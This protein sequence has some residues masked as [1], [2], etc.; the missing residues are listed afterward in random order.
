MRGKYV[1]EVR[2]CTLILLALL[3]CCF[4]CHRKTTSY[5]AI[6]AVNQPD[7]DSIFFVNEIV[8]KDAYTGEYRV[9][10]L[11]RV[12]KENTLP[13]RIFEANTPVYRTNEL[14]VGMIQ[15]PPKCFDCSAAQDMFLLLK[16]NKER[17]LMPLGYYKPDT[18]CAANGVTLP[19]DVARLCVTDSDF[20]T[21]LL[22][23]THYPMRL[24]S[25]WTSPPRWGRYFLNLKDMRQVNDSASLSTFIHL[26]NDT[27]IVPI[28]LPQATDFV[29]WNDLVDK[30]D[31]LPPAQK[32][33]NG[34]N[35]YNSAIAK[36]RPC[37][38]KVLPYYRL[39]AKR[40][41]LGE[42]KKHLKDKSAFYFYS[43]PDLECYK[44]WYITGKDGI[45]TAHIRL[46][47]RYDLWED[48]YCPSYRWD[49]LPACKPKKI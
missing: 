17:V 3:W 49:D 8:K 45:K 18:L 12:L 34:I 42:I 14:E 15:I 13:F 21:M 36:N 30:R 29:K 41:A 2:L 1:S 47:T 19:A 39:E 20:C 35:E 31:S 32:A 22:F 46:M 6:A 38:L 25:G 40:R 5:K 26:L 11:L 44:I 37:I 7:E 28:S 48:F 24:T 43:V 23:L 4:G 9:K 27:G 33:Q 16:K 10:D